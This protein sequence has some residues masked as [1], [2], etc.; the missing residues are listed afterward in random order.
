MRHAKSRCFS[1]GTLA[2]AIL[3]T[4]ASPSTPQTC[5]NPGL[6]VVAVGLTNPRHIRFGPDG[7]LYVTEAGIG[8]SQL[9]T[10]EPVDSSFT[11]NHPYLA[12][13]T[14]RISRILADGT[15]ETVVDG[16]PS[17]RDGFDDALGPTDI[18]WIGGTMYV[19]IQG[20]GCSRGL[21]NDPAGIIRI[22]D[23]GSYTYVA[24][25]STFVRQNPSTV[26][27]LCGPLGDC[28][29]DGVPHTM[30]AHGNR[31]YV[32]ETNHNN[33]LR[34][35][36]RT[37]AIT[38]LYDLSVQDPAPITMI[39]K[40]NDFFIG[41]FDGLIQTFDHKLGPVSTIDQGYGGIVDL[42]IVANRMHVLETSS[43]ATPFAPNNGSVI[44]RDRDGSAESMKQLTTPTLPATAQEIFAAIA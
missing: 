23:D 38:R 15:R 2:A 41:A 31:L 20:G 24:D 29:P 17:A 44:R 39:R 18:A 3:L 30:L 33:I 4:W 10:C 1:A 28:E 5:V 21:P 12:G 25:I 32:V 22:N 36:P 37:G 11:V 16:L 8:G 7:L 9:A 27:P 6:T 13:F 26:E 42:I 19:L 43:A 34:V 35:D 40:G 14:G